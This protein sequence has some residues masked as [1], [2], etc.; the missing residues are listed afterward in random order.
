MKADDIISAVDNA[1]GD[2]HNEDGESDQV[3]YSNGKGEVSSLIDQI[4]D[5]REEAKKDHHLDLAIPGTKEMLWVRFRPF[6]SAKTERR[7]TEYQ[8]AQQ[9]GGPIVLMSSI[10][11]IVDACEQLMLLK[12]EFEGEIGE[13]GKNLIPVDNEIPVGFDERCAELFIKDEEV[14]STILRSKHQSREVVMAMFPTEQ[15]IIA[16]NVTVSR[17]MNDVT[18]D[19]DTGFLQD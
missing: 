5:L 12:P 15:A 13:D 8:K 7:T 10:D 4:A 16:T 19:V 17:W 3:I 2:E 9:R 1:E 6:S 14:R 18:K 11:L